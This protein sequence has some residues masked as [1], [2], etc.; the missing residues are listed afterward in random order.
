MTLDEYRTRRD[1]YELKRADE[2]E[3]LAVAAFYHRAAQQTEDRGGRSYYKYTKLADLYDVAS[4]EAEVFGDEA[5]EQYTELI[6][7]YKRLEIYRERRRTDHGPD[8]RNQ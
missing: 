1:A 4:K 2:M 3:L 6:Q 8:I 5:P 7:R